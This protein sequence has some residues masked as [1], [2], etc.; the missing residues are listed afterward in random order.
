M[1][2]V[3]VVVGLDREGC[4]RCVSNAKLLSGLLIGVELMKGV[5]VEADG[6][7]LDFVIES[8]LGSVSESRSLALSCLI[9]LLCL[10][11]P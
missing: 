8:R 1:V 3:V 5:G 11:Q 6:Y 10:G 2:P 7:I 4:D 9:L